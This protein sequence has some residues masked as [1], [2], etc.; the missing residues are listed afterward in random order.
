MKGMLPDHPWGW[1]LICAF[2]SASCTMWCALMQ[3]ECVTRGVRVRAA[4]I[5]VPE[6][7]KPRNPCNPRNPRNP[8]NPHFFSYKYTAHPCLQATVTCTHYDMVSWSCAFSNCSSA[9]QT[10][11]HA[12]VTDCVF[13][14]MSASVWRQSVPVSYICQLL[15]MH[16]AVTVACSCCLSFLLML[17][18]NHTSKASC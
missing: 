2:S 1:P 16:A 8:R 7:S 18:V 10:F 17:C 6:L 4:A 9:G 11:Y 15:L 12:N 5:F 14:C 3:R 13:C